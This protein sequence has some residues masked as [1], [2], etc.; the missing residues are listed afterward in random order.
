[1][2]QNFLYLNFP[3]KEKAKFNHSPLSHNVHLKKKL[4]I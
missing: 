3:W 4:K 1:M 2:D